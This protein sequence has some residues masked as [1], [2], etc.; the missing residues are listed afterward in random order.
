M[1]D[2]A[3]A[4]ANLRARPDTSAVFL[5]GHSEGS[6]VAIR[7]ATRGPVDGLMLLAGPGRRLDTYE[8][9]VNLWEKAGG[10][11]SG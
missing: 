7:A 10:R 8:P 11:Q 5:A 1:D 4:L 6:T 3:L 2:A 9:L